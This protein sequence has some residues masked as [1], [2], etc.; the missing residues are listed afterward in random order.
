LGEVVFQYDDLDRTNISTS[1]LNL[2]CICCEDSF[3]YLIHPEG[4]AH[5]FRAK[6]FVFD[7][8]YPGFKKPLGYLSEVLRQDSLLF[9]E[10]KQKVIAVRGVPFAAVTMD[11][12]ERGN[13]ES[14]LANQTETGPNDTVQTDIVAGTDHA[15][16]FAIPDVLAAE[17]QMYYSNARVRHSLSS[18]LCHALSVAE[19]GQTKIHANMTHRWLEV[20]IVENKKL[21][22]INHLRWYDQNDIVYYIAAL[23]ENL[24]LDNNPAFE[25]SGTAYKSEMHTHLM[26]YLSVADEKL[27]THLSSEDLNVLDLRT[28]GLCE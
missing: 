27:I 10:F 23:L 14:L 28:I 20:V 2:S 25:F 16:I 22:Y 7:K 19:S 15:L 5:H 9:D 17:I 13:I 24:Q 8:R 18:L 11:E 21:Q 3:S 12:L 26:E 6:S 4:D 1:A